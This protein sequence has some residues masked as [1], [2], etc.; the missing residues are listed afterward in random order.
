MKAELLLQL[1][2]HLE[3]GTLGHAVFDFHIFNSNTSKEYS[4]D[5]RAYRVP[6]EREPGDGPRN[7]CCTNGCAIGECPIVFPDAWH[8]D[9][10]GQPSLRS[11]DATKVI[12]WS[13]HP[14]HNAADFFGI[15][16]ADAKFLFMPV[17]DYH[18]LDT[19]GRLPNNATKEQ[20]A[21]RIR[22]YVAV[23]AK[24]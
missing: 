24:P 18:P 12:G 17:N 3:T 14:V 1:A 19:V 9:S 10:T 7:V 23:N 15:S 4:P 22:A 2:Q 6:S 20:V 13:L 5:G 16:N 8:F 21:A 11:F